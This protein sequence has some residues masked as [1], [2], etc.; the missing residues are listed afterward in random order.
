METLKSYMKS[1]NSAPIEILTNITWLA[2]GV[3]KLD[4]PDE[5]ID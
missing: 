3:S 5:K 1:I 2:N 4:L